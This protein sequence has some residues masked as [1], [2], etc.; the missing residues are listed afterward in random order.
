VIE[1]EGARPLKGE[2]LELTPIVSMTHPFVN[3]ME[4]FGEQVAAALARCQIESNVSDAIASSGIPPVKE[5]G[6]AKA[7]GQVALEKAGE[8]SG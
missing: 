2:G 1:K 4:V 5:K 3:A 7:E 6:G 8:T